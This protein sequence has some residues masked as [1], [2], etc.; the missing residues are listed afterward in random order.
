[1]VPLARQ[2]ETAAVVVLAAQMAQ[3]DKQLAHM[4]QEMVDFMAAVLD[5]LAMAVSKVLAL[6]ALFVSFTQHQA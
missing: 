3:M 4:V 1:M 5:S 6:L 2:T